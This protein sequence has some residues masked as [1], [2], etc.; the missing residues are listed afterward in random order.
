MGN[1]LNQKNNKKNQPKIKVNSTVTRTS[2]PNREYEYLFKILL[3]GD[4]STG[5]SSLLL[6]YTDN[7]FVETFISTIGVDFKIKTSQ[8]DGTNV[9]LQIWDTAGQERFRTITSSYYRG[10]HAILIVYDVTN[11]E[12]F[13]NVSRWLQEVDRYASE[14]VQKILIGNKID[15]ENERKVSSEEGRELAESYCIPFFETSAKMSTTSI[16]ESFDAVTKTLIQIQTE[17]S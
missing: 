7:T 16:G 2:D 10:A 15:L 4:S 1:C 11:R 9:K 17:N 3:I 6:R 8:I 5:K 12:S 14:N 13:E